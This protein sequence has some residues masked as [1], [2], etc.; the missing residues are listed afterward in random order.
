[1]VLLIFK[2]GTWDVSS[3]LHIS[4]TYPLPELPQT[5]V[6]S[7]RGPT[8]KNDLESLRNVVCFVYPLL[9]GCSTPDWVFSLLFP[10]F[11]NL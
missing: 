6:M 3:H 5:A 11:Q 10:Q 7:K 8:K 1:M 9:L 4:N 2:G